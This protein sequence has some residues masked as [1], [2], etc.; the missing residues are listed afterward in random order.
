MPLDTNMSLPTS[1]PALQPLTLDSWKKG[2]ITLID[3]SRVPRDALIEMQ[4]LFLAEDGVPTIRPG[5]DWYGSVAPN[6]AA[7]DGAGLY[8][9]SLGVP[10]LI[11]VA[12][13][14]VYRSVNDGITWQ[15]CT[16]ATTTSGVKAYVVQDHS[17][18]YITTGSDNIL[19]Y[20]GTTTLSTYTSLAAPTGIATA[21]TSSTVM[22]GTGYHRYYKIV[23]VNTVGFT[24]PSAASG[25]V[26]SQLDRVS[27]TPSTDFVTITWTAVSGA[28]RYDIYT[29][30]D[31]TDY[32]YLDTVVG[33]TSTSYRDDGTAVENTN[34][35]A[36]TSNTTQGPKVKRL[37]QIGSRLWGAE[38]TENPWRV[39]FSGAGSYSGYFSAAYDG[40]YIDI[41]LGSQFRPVRVVDY[42]D[43]KGTPY[44]TVWCK[45]ADGRG[46]I[47]Q[48]TLDVLTIGDVS[49]TVP[50]AFRLPGSR[51]TDAPESVVNV[52]ND[53]MFYNSQAFYN[54]GSRAQF[55]NLL[56]TDESS[57]NIRPTVKKIS[58]TGSGGICSIYYEARV[59]FSVP[60]GS[61]TN[62][63]TIVYDTERK[64]WIPEAFTVG[65]ERFFQYVQVGSDGTR[66][67]RLL[68][69]K[70]G[71]TRLTQISDGIAGDY[72][73]PF[74]TSLVTGLY[75]V[76]RNRFD[77]MW[78]EDGEL[79]FSQPSGAIN[80]ELIGIER[81]RGYGTQNTETVQTKTL[82]VGWSTF[83]WSM[84]YWTDTSIVPETFSESSVKRY[85]RVM[86]ELNAYQ[87]RITTNSLDAGYLLRTLQ[88]MGTLTQGGKPRQW[89]I[90][91]GSV[92]GG[93]TIYT[94]SGSPLST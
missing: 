11:I 62:N 8:E 3:K 73:Q 49:I 80:V 15:E 25:D 83:P 66:T 19:R 53:Y 26:Q 91:T 79:E 75:P 69:W 89:R 4:N 36:P 17:Y 22:A 46:C 23:A 33:Q 85:F 37:E 64:A 39:W 58:T 30:A 68:A 82:N 65:F 60:Y 61:T 40:G 41:M 50:N 10:H 51:G 16:G 6:G 7:I 5:L 93:T 48:I 88:I 77:F 24:L 94:G 84:S 71:D 29:S 55:L 78:V 72:G 21:E 67:P 52:L 86:R 76:S 20:D 56:S 28:T 18:L 74:Q 35:M 34:I 92:S 1:V 9:T 44:A 27:W 45:S 43:G 32:V 38:D 31:G 70:K 42:R 47:W 14:K 63:Y 57:A 13:G 2:V 87:W 81:S 12:G 54:L 59:Y 90:G